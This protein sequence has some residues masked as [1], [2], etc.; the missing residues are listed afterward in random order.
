MKYIPLL[1]FVALAACS[2][3]PKDYE[4]TPVTIETAA[5]PVVC[6]L[7][8]REIVRWD[9]A[10]QRPESMSVETAD[11]ICYNEGLRQKNGSNAAETPSTPEPM[12]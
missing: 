12:L 11:K 1:A 6:Q 10:I 9:R 3:D 8:T 5:G 4:S 2:I 7:Y